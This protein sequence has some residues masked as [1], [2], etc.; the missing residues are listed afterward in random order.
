[1]S[2]QFARCIRRGSVI[3]SIHLDFLYGSSLPWFKPSHPQIN[4][5]MIH[6]W[7]LPAQCKL[8]AQRCQ[9]ILCLASTTRKIAY[10]SHLNWLSQ[11]IA[12]WLYIFRRSFPCIFSARFSRLL[13]RSILYSMLVNVFIVDITN[14]KAQRT[15]P[16]YHVSRPV[17]RSNL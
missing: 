2:C 1:M 16:C 15:G 6:T 14:I 12:G 10:F 5:Y 8:F 11:A 17:C 3:L 9:P 13:E 4:E 7:R